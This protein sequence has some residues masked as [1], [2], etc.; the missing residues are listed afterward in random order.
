MSTTKSKLTASVRQAKA[1]T[2]DKAAPTE[3]SPNPQASPGEAAG[4][5]TQ[6]TPAAA[7]PAAAHDKP[8]AASSMSGC[9][10]WPD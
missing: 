9:H 7:A 4:S 1:Q 5:V 3:A 8:Q 10:V 2:P 6:S